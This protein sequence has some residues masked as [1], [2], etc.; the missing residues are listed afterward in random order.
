MPAITLNG[1][2]RAV[3]PGKT[4]LALLEDL[5]LARRG[6]LAVEVNAE[7]VPKSEHATTLLEEGDRVEVVTML[8]GG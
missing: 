6:G 4:V 3:T 5:G 7:V 8:A 1:E 2:A